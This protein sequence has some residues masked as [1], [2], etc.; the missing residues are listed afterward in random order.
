[1]P[2]AGARVPQD[3]RP[4]TRECG[5]GAFAAHVRALHLRARP[6]ERT[7]WIEERR[8]VREDARGPARAE[9][10]AERPALERDPG[11]D[12]GDAQ[13]AARGERGCEHDGDWVL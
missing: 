13:D 2:H 10:V 1:M 3:A 6:R 9:V 5:C 11:G 12:A 7:A 4:R 8:P